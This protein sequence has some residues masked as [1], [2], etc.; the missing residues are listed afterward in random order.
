MGG[1][2]ESPNPLI[3]FKELRISRSLERTGKFYG[4]GE[5]RGRVSELPSMICHKGDKR[6][7]HT[8]DQLVPH[9]T[10]YILE[11]KNLPIPNRKIGQ[12]LRNVKRILTTILDMSIWANDSV[13]VWEFTIRILQT[14]SAGTGIDETLIKARQRREQVTR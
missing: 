7:R 11:S 2:W 10:D 6:H 14:E 12:K 8:Q 5:A 1:Q 9:A 4:W 13:V 3:E